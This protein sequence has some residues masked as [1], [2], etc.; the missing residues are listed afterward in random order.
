M[1]TSHDHLPLR[2][3]GLAAAGSVVLLGIA[4]G[5]A[6]AHAEVSASD[7]RA[8]AENVTLSFTS[9][10]ESDSAGITELRVVLPQGIAPDAVTLK[11]A[12]ENWKL[13]A[14]P[15]GYSVGGAA[16]A[17]GTD[18][19]YSI[20]VRQ[21]PDAKSLAF[22]T[23]ET[24]GDGKVSRWIEVPADGQKVDNPAPLLK[25]QPAAPGA[26]PIAPGPSPT[27][28]PA[29]APSAPTAQ[30]SSTAPSAPAAS[31]DARQANAAG[32]GSGNGVVVAV[33]AAVLVL[34]GAGA[35]RWTR[36]RR[37]S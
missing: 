8:L 13:T 5:P 15:D 2:R 10:A 3:L 25:L 35:F 4:A 36:R 14:T 6:A 26:K 16:L 31:P 19:E 34:G 27:P 29:P 7:P 17:T 1:H 18:A 12:P 9:E 32:S 11:E 21:L 37:Q 28:T 24:Y 30:P 33:V 22:K 23:L 20:T